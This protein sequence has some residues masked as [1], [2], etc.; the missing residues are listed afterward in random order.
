MSVIPSLLRPACCTPLPCG[1]YHPFILGYSCGASATITVDWS[2]VRFVTHDNNGVYG[3]GSGHSCEPCEVQA[4][5]GGYQ[6]L[7]CDPSYISS[8]LECADPDCA[9][10]THYCCYSYPTS[11][12]A[13]IASGTWTLC[14][15]TYT[16]SWTGNPCAPCA[17]CGCGEIEHVNNEWDCLSL[18]ED[19]FATSQ[20]YYTQSGL[21]CDRT[22]TDCCVSP[23]DNRKWQTLTDN[24][25]LWAWRS[26]APSFPT[27][28]TSGNGYDKSYCA[29]AN[30]R[31][32]DIH[33][34]WVDDALVFTRATAVPGWVPGDIV[35]NPWVVITLRTIP[36]TGYGA[37]DGACAPA[38]FACQECDCAL[39]SG[40]G[41]CFHPTSTPT[42]SGSGLPYPRWV[43]IKV[44]N[45]YEY[46]YYGTNAHYASWANAD[47]SLSAV[48]S[49]TA[50]ETP[51][52]MGLRIEPDSLDTV[53][54]LLTNDD[55]ATNKWC[56][57]IQG[58]YRSASTCSNPA[59]QEFVA[60]N[61]DE[62]ELIYMDATTA[63]FRARHRYHY[64]VT[65]DL[66]CRT[67]Y[68]ALGMTLGQNCCGLLPDG[69]QEV[70]Y[71]E[72][73][74]VDNA[75][76]NGTWGTNVPTTGTCDPCCPPSDPCP[77]VSTGGSTCD[78]N[79]CSDT[80][81]LIASWDAGGIKLLCDSPGYVLAGSP[82]ASI[83]N[84]AFSIPCVW[85]MDTNNEDNNSTG[86][87]PC[88]RNMGATCPSETQNGSYPTCS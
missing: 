32:E 59:L 8:D 53:T 3:T 27:I 37:F 75:P 61:S 4:C 60:D 31:M 71:Y 78:P 69:C 68:G 1:N 33:A 28:D 24:G 9:N 88:D 83:Y 30:E 29:K 47:P 46:S 5:D 39:T 10:G 12:Y 36:S 74:A 18:V 86:C 22:E 54:G 67:S 57:N 45:A 84:V 34:G 14:K 2:D 25:A 79:A 66:I 49:V 72:G 63:E 26:Y 17:P 40:A 43:S 62:F 77:Q 21:P 11:T 52:W 7:A 56:N 73:S 23:L 16:G 13:G 48:V 80:Y 65:T 55:V 42:Q 15:T 51:F 50:S 35:D 82:T 19:L 87:V 76:C 70:W 64:R 85:K 81:Y 6:D 38:N 58:F 41:D 20:T 44:D